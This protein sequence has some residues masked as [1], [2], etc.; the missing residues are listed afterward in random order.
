MRT[1][2][3]VDAEGFSRHRDVQLPSIHTEIRRVVETA[4]ERSGL[5]WEAVRLLQ[6]TGDGLLAILPLDAMIPLIHP[7][8]DHL[9]NALADA[10]P[11]LRA[12]GVKLRMRVALH[13]GLVDD[14]DPVTAGISTATN[15]VSRLLDCEPLRAAL[16]DSDPD[17]TFVAA[18]VSREAFD[19]FVCSGRTTLRP[20]QFTRVQAE[21]KQFNQVAYLYVPTPSRREQRDD[22]PEGGGSDAPAP[23]PAGGPSLG[24]VSVAGD[25]A[26][27]AFGN[28]VGGDF[29]QVRP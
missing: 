13:F 24:N 3:V 19:T 25:G 7:F 29:R 2:L 16:R 9:Q 20:S 21:V 28:Q 14:E 1:L 11:K 22:P 27:N 23:T 6:S 18:I 12:G 4:C 17:V 8:L 26:Q 15:D 10:A 5:A